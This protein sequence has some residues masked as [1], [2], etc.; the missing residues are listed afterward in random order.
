MSKTRQLV[1]IRHGESVWNRDNLFTGWTDVD[2]SDQG[3]NEAREAGRQLLVGRARVAQERV[4]GGDGERDRAE[5][6]TA[7]ARGGDQVGDGPEQRGASLD[8]VA[9]AHGRGGVEPGR[10]HHRPEPVVGQL[11]VEPIEVGGGLVQQAVGGVAPRPLPPAGVRVRRGGQVPP[12]PLVL[13][14]PA[15]VE[16]RQGADRVP[17]RVGDEAA[18]RSEPGRGAAVAARR[19]AV[20]FPSADDVAHRR[21]DVG[22]RCEFLMLSLWDSTESITAFA[23]DDPETAVFYPEDDRF[24]IERE[25]TVDHYEVETSEGSL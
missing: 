1:L 9:P 10:Q 2:L 4:S 24:L 13:L 23:G 22:D 17:G 6:G 19:D 20:L 7:G 5:G 3:R 12:R 25:L 15:P 8:D 14:H 11:A 16:E 21:R 18:G